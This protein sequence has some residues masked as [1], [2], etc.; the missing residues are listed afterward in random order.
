M[1][2][3][4]RVGRAG[5]VPVG[6]ILARTPGDAPLV[7]ADL[8]EH[9][10]AFRGHDHGAVAGGRIADRLH[11]A[12]APADQIAVEPSSRG[13]VGVGASDNTR[14]ELDRNDGHL[15]PHTAYTE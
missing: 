13:V 11:D 14:R 2:E 9:G 6:V 15:P 4:R 3:A 10:V 1:Q 7:A 8:E 12:A 5:K